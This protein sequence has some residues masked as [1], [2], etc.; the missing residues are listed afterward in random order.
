MHLYILLSRLTLAV[1]ALCSIDDALAL[2]P[3]IE[4]PEVHP[5][6]EAVPLA[7]TPSAGPEIGTVTSMLE[8]DD[9]AGNHLYVAGDFSSIGNRESGGFAR[10]DGKHWISLLPRNGTTTTGEGILFI[11]QITTWRD[12]IYAVASVGSDSNDAE[13]RVLRWNGR[14]FEML[15]A[16]RFSR[17]VREILSWNDALLVTYEGSIGDDRFAFW[18]GNRFVIPPGQSPYGA[19]FHPL[20]YQGQLHG[21]LYSAEGNHVARW[22]GARWEPLPSPPGR[23]ALLKLFAAGDRIALTT[24]I[25]RD[26]AGTP[27][28]NGIQLWDGNRWTQLQGG[29]PLNPAGA[30]YH[31][32]SIYLSRYKNCL[33]SLTSCQK[34]L[35]VWTNDV[36]Q[37]PRIDG[38]GTA[39]RLF[40]TSF[41]LLAAGERDLFLFYNSEGRAASSLMRLS[42]E[43]EIAAFSPPHSVMPYALTIWNG[44]PV[45][46]TFITSTESDRINCVAQLQAGRWQPIGAGLPP[47]RQD[48]DGRVSHIAA[49]N[50]EIFAIFAS[51]ASPERVW[52]WGGEEW[53]RDD[54]PDSWLQVP[55]PINSDGRLLLV[56][57]NHIY[58]RSGDQWTRLA[59]MPRRGGRPP[60]SHF[61]GYPFLADG[62]LYAVGIPTDAPPETAQT[63]LRLDSGR[64]VDV[65]PRSGALLSA[66]STDQSIFVTVLEESEDETSERVVSLLRLGNGGWTP[67]Y[68]SLRRISRIIGVGPDLLLQ[69]EDRALILQGSDVWTL[70]SCASQLGPISRLGEVLVVGFREPAISDSVCALSRA[71]PST[72]LISPNT[73]EPTEGDWVQLD[74]RLTAPAVPTGGSVEI[75]GMPA[76]GCT[77]TDLVA[78][79][80]TT[81]VGSCLTRFSR[82]MS[83]ELRARYTGFVGHDY[84]AW[85]PAE[86]SPVML[87]VSRRLLRD[88]FESP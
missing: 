63:L 71:L 76:G 16:A 18:D 4:L 20:I 78:A 24:T 67:V 5:T 36:W 42:H 26:S 45:A 86:A 51:Q 47:C 72:L 80:A 57:L 81:A 30:V 69:A 3:A 68:R 32:G 58:E 46:G 54:P 12:E 55:R 29:R 21:I 2:P 52:R 31:R 9:G 85:S 50:N 13:D 56:D 23:G 59:P 65:G 27:F 61:E 77:V 84:T 28:D 1:V 37:T 38:L 19:P 8:W 83:V 40:S 74:V 43:E 10:F 39:R 17:G 22:D 6:Y 62:S 79:D 66:A 41:G 75:V 70:P 14:D 7:L 15:P 82:G 88:G 44:T 64:W 25:E 34:A 33:Y 11:R 53:M 48:R 73:S 60:L 87:E 35:D 49:I